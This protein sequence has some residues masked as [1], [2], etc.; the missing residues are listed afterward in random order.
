MATCGDSGLCRWSSVL[1]AAE[2]HMRVRVDRERCFGYGRCVDLVPE[3]F[4]LDDDDKSVADDT[5][6][7]PASRLAMAVW[8]C[9]MQALTLFD[10]DGEIVAPELGQ[11]PEDA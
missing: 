3:V 2:P 7:V 9:P 8:A 6:D 11:S 10:D 4:H 1:A 5:T